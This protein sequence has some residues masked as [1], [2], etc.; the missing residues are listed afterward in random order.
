M[1]F[2]S[3]FS[4]SVVTA[5]RGVFSG[6]VD[7]TGVTTS[8]GGFV[9]AVTG[10]TTGTHTGSVAG[11]TTIDG[12][13]ATVTTLSATTSNLTTVNIGGIIT[14]GVTTPATLTGDVTDYALSGATPVCRSASSAS[15]TIISRTGSALQRQRRYNVGTQ[16]IVI[17]HDDAVNGTASLRYKL[18]GATN[19]TLV[20][21]A[22]GD[23]WYDPTTARWRFSQL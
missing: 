20:P 4:G 23:E 3:R 21:D 14:E 10:N 22:S 2:L 17:R 5:V 13:T 1:G 6:N 12:T 7:V 15:W 8:T 11:A 18:R 16:N 19:F 9:G